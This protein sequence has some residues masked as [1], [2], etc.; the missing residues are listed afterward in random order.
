VRAQSAPRWQFGPNLDSLPRG[1]MLVPDGHEQVVD[2]A[3]PS[4][5]ALLGLSI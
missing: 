4:S 5:P 1:P 2:V 3:A